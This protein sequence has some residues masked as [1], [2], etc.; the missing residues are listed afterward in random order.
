MHKVIASRCRSGCPLGVPA[1]AARTGPLP[2][3]EVPVPSRSP[4]GLRTTS[5]PVAGAEYTCTS[6]NRCRS[7]V[8]AAIPASPTIRLAMAEVSVPVSDH[9]LSGPQRSARR[10]AGRYRPVW[11][12]CPSRAG[13]SSSFSLNW[14]VS[15]GRKP[16]IITWRRAK[17]VG[18]LCSTGVFGSNRF[19]AQH[20]MEPGNGDEI[21][22][23][24]PDQG[25]GPVSRVGQAF[26]LTPRGSRRGSPTFSLVASGCSRFLYSC[27]IRVLGQTLRVKTK[28]EDS[29][30]IIATTVG[31]AVWNC[32]GDRLV[33]LRISW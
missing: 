5:T 27:V 22:H 9:R 13:E 29:F 2:V 4:S 15:T 14:L 33:I 25:L 16:A 18:G 17:C 31:C 10:G 11:W 12:L 7:V 3:A 19:S 21:E 30:V 28:H 26:P 8:W 6:S 1:G 23:S 24:V 20:L 32:A